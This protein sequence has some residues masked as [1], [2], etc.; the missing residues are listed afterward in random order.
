VTVNAV[1]ST[2]PT[3]TRPGQLCHITEEEFS[4][5]MTDDV[6]F[7]ADCDTNGNDTN[8]TAL[9]YFSRISKHY[10]H[11]VKSSPSSSPVS[12]H[13]MLFPV[14]ADSGA[15]YHMFRD[16]SFFQTLTPTTGNVLLGD[17]KTSLSIQGVGTVYCRIG[18]QVLRIPHVRYV[19]DLSESIYS[20]FLH[21]KT[22]HHGLES[23]YENGLF[24]QFPQFKTQAIIGDNDIYLDMVPA[25]MNNIDQSSSGT[26]ATLDTS[27]FC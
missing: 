5:T 9:M 25:N 22:P 26:T 2:P 8:E 15:N 7:D 27:D 13:E 10:L 17:G 3:N 19:P 4:D 18:S 23:S 21:V 1:S 14:I 11:L 20:L 16:R 12:R 6:T 24:L